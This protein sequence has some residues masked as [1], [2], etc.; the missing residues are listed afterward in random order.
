MR[1]LFY[2]IVNALG[3]NLLI[4]CM[5]GYTA[6]KLVVQKR[7]ELQK[8]AASN[9]KLAMF[10][11][12]R[13]GLRCFRSFFDF[14]ALAALHSANC[15]LH[16]NYKL[17]TAVESEKESLN[18]QLKV[19]LMPVAAVEEAS[20]KLADAAKPLEEIGK[21]MGEVG[22]QMEQESKKAELATRSLIQEALV[23]GAAKL[24]AK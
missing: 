19:S 24:A 15:A 18:G 7:A 9:V 14:L 16:R 8:N 22:K 20:K 1:R 21:R 12:K 11:V 23:N 6:A 2:E 3:R 17:N 13:A 5:L 4:V 10:S